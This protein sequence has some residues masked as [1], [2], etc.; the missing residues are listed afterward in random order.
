[1]HE[2]STSPLSMF[3]EPLARTLRVGGAVVAEDNMFAHKMGVIDSKQQM[4]I[5]VLA[6]YR[7]RSRQVTETPKGR[8]VWKTVHRN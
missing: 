8:K 4:V 7:V 6:M 2:F 1:M 5:Q 3:Y